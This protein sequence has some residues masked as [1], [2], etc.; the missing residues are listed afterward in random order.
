MVAAG[1]EDDGQQY[2]FAVV[3]D[4]E[5]LGALEEIGSTIDD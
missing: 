5:A 2:L 1:E 3:I 4:V